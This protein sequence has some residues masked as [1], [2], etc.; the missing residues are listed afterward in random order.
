MRVSVVFRFLV[1]VRFG[2]YARFFKGSFED[3]V[4]ALHVVQKFAARVL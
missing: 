2:V 3:S 4:R 1:G